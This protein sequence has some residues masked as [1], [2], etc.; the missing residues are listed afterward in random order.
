MNTLED[1]LRAALHE[2]SA[3]IT[4]RS[5]PPLRLHDGWRRPGRPGAGSRRWSAWLA[6]LAAAA[7]VAVV[8]AASLA[9]SATFHDRARQPQG[10]ATGQPQ[11]APTGRPAALRNVPPYYVDLVGMPWSRSAEVRATTTGAVLATVRPPKPFAHFNWVS[12]ASDDRTFIL[13]AQRWWPI[14]RG[15][16]AEK[17]DN[18]TPLK[19]FRLRFNPAQG[20][21]TL[22]AVALPES[23]EAAQVGGIGLSPDGSKLALSL[24]QS[25][26]IIT[27]ATGAK[28]E[29]V[30]S[31]GGWAGNFKPFGQ[32]FSWTA[33]GR[34][35]AFQ[36]WGGKFHSTAHVRVLDTTAPGGSI[37]SAKPVVT[38]QNRAEV[39]SFNL[40]N[41]L[42]TPDGT[43]IV[44]ATTIYPRQLSRPEKLAIT[45]FSTRTGKVVASADRFEMPEGRQDVLWTSP[46]GS[47]LIV[48]DPRGKQDAGVI[49]VL[50]EGRFTPLPRAPQTSQIAW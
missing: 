11:G 40:G 50:A 49:G 20:T 33:D 23:L 17:R 34:K 8:I 9:L 24:R 36:Q 26:Q 35:L 15:G 38:F 13:A 1:T 22:T 12:G 6:P 10:P 30:L 2:T 5:V 46:S 14:G 19:F 18:T 31:V 39:M 42:I 4:P 37:L 27:L 28:R 29:W 32:P 47:T 16:T 48:I 21:A 41:T 7:A 44:T 45:T 25:I 3:E 43:K